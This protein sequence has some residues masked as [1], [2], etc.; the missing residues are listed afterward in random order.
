[1]LGLHPKF[2]GIKNYQ[3]IKLYLFNIGLALEY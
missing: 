2:D 3:L 1:M